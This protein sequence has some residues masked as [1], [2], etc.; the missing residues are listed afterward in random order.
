MAMR[1]FGIRVDDVFFV[2]SLLFLCLSLYNHA[3][4]FSTIL[5]G[6]PIDR[7][8]DPDTFHALAVTCIFGVAYD[9]VHSIVVVCV[10]VRIPAETI[11]EDIELT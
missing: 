2:P 4:G 11:N 7:C 10:A 8:C 6:Y 9:L 1:R 3:L 5:G